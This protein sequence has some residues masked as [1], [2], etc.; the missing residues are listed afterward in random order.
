M[1]KKYYCPYPTGDAGRL[2]RRGRELGQ[3]WTNISDKK[4]KIELIGGY[5]Y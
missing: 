2:W 1:S 4:V 5:A 3:G